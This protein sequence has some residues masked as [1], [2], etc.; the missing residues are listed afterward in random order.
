MAAFIHPGLTAILMQP[1]S[2][3]SQ[4]PLEIIANLDAVLARLAKYGQRIR[5]IR[6]PGGILAVGLVSREI[7]ICKIGSIQRDFPALIE[8]FESNPE[9]EQTV[10]IALKPRCI[11]RFVIYVVSPPKIAAQGKIPGL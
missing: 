7:L 1:D 11:I 3:A 5:R 10:G 4:V 9:I 2:S 8:V 6:G